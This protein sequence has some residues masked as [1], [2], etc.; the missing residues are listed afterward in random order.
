[1]ENYKKYFGMMAE[2]L[3]KEDNL[4]EG[5][6]CFDHKSYDFDIDIPS[7][8]INDEKR[9]VD[10]FRINYDATE[11]VVISGNDMFTLY[12][13]TCTFTDDDFDKMGM[14]DLLRD[15]YYETEYSFEIGDF[16]DDFL[17]LN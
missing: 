3:Y 14:L 17:E 6:V 15:V 11:I 1:M 4:Y 12:I 8:I 10:E 7:I 13:P 5:V 2:L 9:L 16:E